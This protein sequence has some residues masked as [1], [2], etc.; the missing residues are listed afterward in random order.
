MRLKSILK[1]PSSL[2]LGIVGWLGGALVST[3]YIAIEVQS[4]VVG[5]EPPGAP[6]LLGN[7]FD[8]MSPIVVSALGVFDSDSDGLFASDIPVAIY[9][10]TTMDRV[11]PVLVFTTANAGSAEGGS[12]FL[13]LDEPVSLPAGFQGSIVAG[14]YAGLGEPNGNVAHQVR[15]WAFQ[16]G[17]GLITMGL[18]RYTFTSA[19]SYPTGAEARPE[20]FPQGGPVFAAGTF[21]YSDAAV[22]EPSTYAVFTAA[23]LVGTAAVRAR[24]AR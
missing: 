17:G 12:R 8:V 4:G 11:T 19:F 10:R 3:G 6:L 15:Q 16:G 18:S 2:A 20:D 5:A 22:P 1:R 21:S 23:L 24:R 7:D 9:D 13:T 14:N